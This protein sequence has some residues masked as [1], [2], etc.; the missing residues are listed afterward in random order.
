MRF[1]AELQ[2]LLVPL[3][4]P[5][6]ATRSMFFDVALRGEELILKSLLDEAIDPD[7]TDAF[8][9]T[10][11]HFAVGSSHVNVVR[12]LLEAGRGSLQNA[13][14]VSLQ[15]ASKGSLRNAEPVLN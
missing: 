5:D 9:S 11:L 15:N 12:L 3:V 4:V 10:A 1:P 7:T 13:R 6:G 2:L 14:E 8:E